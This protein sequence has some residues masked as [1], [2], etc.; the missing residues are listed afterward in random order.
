MRLYTLYP[1]QIDP[2]S[3]MNDWRK[4]GPVKK[5]SLVLQGNKSVLA[6]LLAAVAEV[7]VRLFL[8][9]KVKHR[10]KRLSGFP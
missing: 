7:D 2:K 4:L 3:R 6:R 5:Q 10:C 1:R 8:E 9:S